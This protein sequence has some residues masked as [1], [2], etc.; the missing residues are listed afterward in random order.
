M[1]MTI[2]EVEQILG[3]P[4]ATVRFYEKEGLIEPKREKNGYRDYSQTD[5]IRLKKIIILR[6]IGLSVND[7]LDIFNGA[8]TMAEVLKDNIVNLQE[9][10][11]VLSGAKNLS[12]KMLEDK[13]EISLFDADMY[14]NIIDKEEKK[15]NSFIDIAKDIAR[16]EKGILASY[17]SWTSVDGEVYDSFPKF[18][19][20][21]V[22]ATVAVGCIICM[23]RGTWNIINFFDG[24]IGIITIILVEAVISVPLYLL[25]KKYSW[26]RENRNKVLII[27]CLIICAVLLF[28][29]NIL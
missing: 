27:T 25:G 16:M 8:K 19:L 15:G 24:I 6:K 12:R 7:I 9:Q 3:I 11:D 17:F 29:N 1:K 20:N 5:I 10:I 26:I 21:V 2:K 28:F 4:R 18:I 23:I 13:V 22:I 14:W